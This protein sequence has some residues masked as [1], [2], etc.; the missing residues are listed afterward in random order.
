MKEESKQLRP[1][2]FRLSRDEVYKGWA[3]M[4]GH[5]AITIQ[6]IVSYHCFT[7]MTVE[8]AK[9]VINNNLPVVME[10]ENGEV[11]ACPNNSV[12]L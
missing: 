4:V 1:Q 8:Y 5:V 3:I 6:N 10:T 11:L 12:L 7:C 9:H 2:S